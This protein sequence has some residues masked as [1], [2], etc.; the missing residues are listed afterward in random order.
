MEGVNSYL[1]EEGTINK[2]QYETINFINCTKN[3]LN[4]IFPYFIHQ[5]LINNDI[6]KSIIS[7][8]LNDDIIIKMLYPYNENNKK[9]IK[10]ITPSVLLKRLEFSNSS[11]YVFLRDNSDY[12]VVD[13]VSSLNRKIDFNYTQYK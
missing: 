12:L 8:K 5:V 7:K 1:F 2:V 9:I 11:L 6:I 10:K 4:I 13:V 3:N